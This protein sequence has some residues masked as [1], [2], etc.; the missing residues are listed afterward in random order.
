MN[1]LLSLHDVSISGSTPAGSRVIVD[2]LS[3]QVSEG[4]SLALVGESGSGKS[5]TALAIMG[6][7]PEGEVVI[8]S[9]SIEFAGTDLRAIRGRERRRITGTDMAMI[10]Q[11]PMT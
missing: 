9:G 11:E 7:L 5:I 10:F 1:C 6:L 8:R 4:E 2:R 3:L